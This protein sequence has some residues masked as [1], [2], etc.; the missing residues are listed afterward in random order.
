MTQRPENEA[1]IVM[2]C[3]VLLQNET[4]LHTN[5]HITRTYLQHINHSK[6]LLAAIVTETL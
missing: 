3:C 4:N 5:Y 1:S 2:E 6:D